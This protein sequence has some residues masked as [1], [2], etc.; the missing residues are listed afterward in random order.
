MAQDHPADHLDKT[1]LTFVI[2]MA[3][4]IAALA[5]TIFPHHDAPTA[6]PSASGS[7]PS[8]PGTNPAATPQKK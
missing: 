6:S 5:Y 2:L 4:F 3:I 1:A 7:G 8:A